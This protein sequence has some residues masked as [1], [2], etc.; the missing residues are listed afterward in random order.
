[1]AEAGSTELDHFGGRVA[2]ASNG[3]RGLVVEQVIKQGCETGHCQ[4]QVFANL[5]GE[6]SGLLDEVPSV[7]CSEL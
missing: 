2:P 1:M 7:A 3:H 5:T 4:M 6:G